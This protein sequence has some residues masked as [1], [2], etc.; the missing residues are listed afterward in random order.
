MSK[1]LMCDLC[2]KPIFNLAR[3]ESYKIKAKNRIVDGIIWVNIDAH[4]DCVEALLSQKKKNEECPP[5][6]GSSMQDK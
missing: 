4:D 3:A 1:I 5:C 2:G 6:G